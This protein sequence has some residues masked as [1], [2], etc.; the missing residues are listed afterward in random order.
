ML[1]NSG[2]DEDSFED[3]CILYMKE[4]LKHEISQE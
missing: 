2:E 1:L 3:Y 4:C